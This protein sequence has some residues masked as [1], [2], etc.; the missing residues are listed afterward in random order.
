MH[1]VEQGGVGVSPAEAD[2]ELDL[3]ALGRALWRKKWLILLPTLLVAIATLVI[4]N[5]ITPRYKSEA[6]IAVEGRENVFLRPEAEKSIDRAV[7]DQE[8]I[9][10][11]VQILQSRD[12]ARQVIRELKLG[13]R[14]EFD[15]VLK[16]ISPISTVLALIGFGRDRLSMTPEER[17][18]EIYYDRLTVSAV[19]R[20]RV[21]TIEFMSEDPELAAKVVNAIVD[22]YMKMQ[23]QAKVDQTRSAS[24]YLAN[25]ITQL[26]KTVQ[27]A[28]AKVDEFRAKANLFIGNNE[29]NLNTQQLGELTTQLATARA[30][31]ADLDAR[32]KAIRDMLKNGKSVESSDIANSDLLKRLIEQRVLLRAQLA[33]QSS[34]LLG[35][36]PRIQELNAQ[37]NAL[38]TQIRGELERLVL[39]IEND[40]RIAGSRVEQ[41]TEAINRIKSQI[42]SSVPQDVQ[43]RALEREAKAQRDLL[44]SYLARYREATA[45]ENIDAEPAEARV[46]SRATV[47]NVPAFPKTVPI[48]IVATLAT[49]FLMMA[50]VLSSEILRQGVPT[51]ARQRPVAPGGSDA[52]L[53]PAMPAPAPSKTRRSLFGL[54]RRKRGAADES[55]DARPQ[56]EVPVRAAPKAD[57]VETLA[58]ALTAMGEPGRRIVLFGAGRNVGTTYTALSLAR[59][60]SAKGTR[61]VLADLALQAPNLSVTSVEPQAPGF[62]ELAR[63][64]ASFGDVITRDK[65]SRVHLV[66]TGMVDGDAAAIFASP[67]LTITL[68]ALARAYDHLVIDGGAVDEAPIRFFAG[69]APRAVLVAKDLAAAATLDARAKLTAAGFAEV[70]SIQSGDERRDSDPVAA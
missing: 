4:V 1:S 34:T 43:L 27:E 63:G 37:I 65:F 44:E 19:E 66:S 50:F 26:R 15:P 9:A 58:N 29:T 51:R 32:S 16:G 36:H 31:K 46:I 68:E 48:V 54:F 62:A 12:I 35:R 38:D 5:Q 6:K 17:V 25:E 45:R 23:Q 7:A 47:S 53:S 18:M 39:A 41:T 28:D 69:F 59:A 13:E 20:S 22:A 52:P 33:E 64:T 2:N 30:Q 42:S 21:I 61:V 56:I 3:Q 40:A 14:P 10:T 60:L 57:R 67:R 11:Q 8:A 49:L 24:A 70:V 55:K